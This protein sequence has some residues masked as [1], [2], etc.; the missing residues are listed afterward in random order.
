M[1]ESFLV[2]LKKE[3]VLWVEEETLHKISQLTG[4]FIKFSG[5]KSNMLS[6]GNIDLSN[7]SVDF[8]INRING[9]FEVIS[10]QVKTDRVGSCVVGRFF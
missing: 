6:E 1:T 4:G 8:K 3:N 2:D 10:D 7:V 9:N 5:T